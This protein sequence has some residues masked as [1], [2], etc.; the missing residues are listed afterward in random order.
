MAW[1]VCLSGLPGTGKSTVARALAGRTGALWLRIDRI[2]Q[3]M[4][5]SHMVTGDLADGGYAAAGAM[6]GAALEQGFDVIADSVNPIAVT[7]AAWQAVSAGARA[8]HLDVELVCTDRAEHRRRVE[9]RDAGVPGLVLPDWAAVEAR[10]YEPW[11]GPV[12][13][14]DTADLTPDVAAERIVAAL[15]ARETNGGGTRADTRIRL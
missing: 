5:E 3:A 13:C 12:L 4:R 15:G 9:T 7:R 6:A 14:L 10:V 11:Q 8:V 2:E 1:M